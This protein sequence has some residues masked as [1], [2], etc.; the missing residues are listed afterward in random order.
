MTHITPRATP[1][2]KT[3][4]LVNGQHPTA[5]PRKPRLDSPFLPSHVRATV[6]CPF[7]PVLLPLHQS[8][9]TKTVR[10]HQAA[11]QKKV[12]LGIRHSIPSTKNNV[13]DTDNFHTYLHIYYI[14]HSNNSPMHPNYSTCYAFSSFLFT[15]ARLK[16]VEWHQD[17]SCAKNLSNCFC[18]ASFDDCG[19]FFSSYFSTSTNAQ[20]APRRLTLPS[21]VWISSC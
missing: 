11:K 1:D 18:L 8:K 17:D 15:T 21:P 2:S 20:G 13:L 7:L 9:T 4:Q 14:Y 10:Q 16:L 3:A 19:L 12:N 6:T 5:N